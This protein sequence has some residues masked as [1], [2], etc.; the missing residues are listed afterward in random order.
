LRA[1]LRQELET[2]LDQ[3]GIPLLLISHDPE[4]V[5]MFGQQVVHLADGRVQV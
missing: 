2:V 1:H 4:D 3:T 5:D